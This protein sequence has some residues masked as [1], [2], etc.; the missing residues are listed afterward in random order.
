MKIPKP[1]KI[2]LYFLLGAGVLIGMAVLVI[3]LG[4]DCAGEVGKDLGF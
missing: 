4:L 3:W 1:L 2:V